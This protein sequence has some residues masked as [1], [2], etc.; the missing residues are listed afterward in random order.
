LDVAVNPGPQDGAIEI[1][2]SRDTIYSK[3]VADKDVPF[4]VKMD[5]QSISG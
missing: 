5:G 4:V 3:N 1:E 2:L